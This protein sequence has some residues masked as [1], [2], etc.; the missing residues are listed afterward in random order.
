M[1]GYWDASTGEI[2]HMYF[3]SLSLCVPSL[4]L[5]LELSRTL[6]PTLDAKRWIKIHVGLLSR[7]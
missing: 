5:K 6:S 3:L 4:V 1:L 2:L 7:R